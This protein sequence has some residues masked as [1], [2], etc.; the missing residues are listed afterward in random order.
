MEYKEQPAT[1]INTCKGFE[2]VCN[3]YRNQPSVVVDGKPY[4][5]E[6]K[7]SVADDKPSLA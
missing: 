4:V 6:D 1:I 7:S 3:K 2:K 5:V